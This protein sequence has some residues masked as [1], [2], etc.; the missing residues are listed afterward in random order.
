MNKDFLTTTV[1][2]GDMEDIY[3]R[4][5]P[6]ERL[7]GSRVLITGATGM[8][9]AYFIYFL[10]WLNEQHNYGIKILAYVR[11][12]EKCTY[13]FGK[14][15]R[16]DYFKVCT[17]SICKTLHTKAKIDYIIHGAS[18][19][20]REFYDS[21]P[22][23]VAEPNVLG[24]YNLLKL[25]QE[26]KIKGLLLLSS[27]A[28][29]GNPGVCRFDE[30]VMGSVDTLFPSS[31]YSE[32]K[33]M[34]ETFCE[35]F[36]REYDVPA[37]IARVVFSFAPTMDLSRDKRIFSFL[38]NCLLHKENIVLKS[39][40]KGAMPWCYGSDTIAAF[41]HILLQ[42]KNGEAY[43]VSHDEEFHSVKEVAELA[44]GI[45]SGITVVVP[46]KNT[47]VS[48]GGMTRG[49]CPTAQ[50]LKLLGWQPKYTVK[51]AIERCYRHFSELK[52]EEAAYAGK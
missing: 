47:D 50:K 27:A 11:S 46:A 9:P 14:Y 35:A 10:I 33:R 15:C 29:Y 24:V 48:G 44:A 5:I 2:K 51:E 4:N 45:E 52:A 32:S 3:G 18:M 21:N 41:L 7:R 28:I 13:V 22:V 31:C 12:R 40:G 26:K 38:V 17:D 49:L 20:S 34:A 19:A 8:L 25:A 37:R 23:E 16:K 1:I 6:W 36:A 30:Q 42:G 39:D 43:N